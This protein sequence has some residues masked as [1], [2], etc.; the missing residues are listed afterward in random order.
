MDFPE[1]ECPNGIIVMDDHLTEA[2]EQGVLSAG[3][4][5]ASRVHIVASC[6]FPDRFAHQLPIKRLGCDTGDYL[7][8]CIEIIDAQRRGDKVRRQNFIEPHFA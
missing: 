3:E 5:V 1:S 8:I 2:V 4:D 6:N 7:R